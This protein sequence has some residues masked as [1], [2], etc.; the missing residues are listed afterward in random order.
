MVIVFALDAAKVLSKSFEP[1]SG[2]DM[3]H[4][5]FYEWTPSPAGNSR[6]PCVTV[7]RLCINDAFSGRA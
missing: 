5:L 4:S 2:V 6:P 7:E 3:E 1:V